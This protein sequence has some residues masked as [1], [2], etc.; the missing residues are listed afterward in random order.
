MMLAK[1]KEVKTIGIVAPSFFIEKNDKF[2]AGVN[3]LRNKGVDLKFGKT[4]FRRINNT[5]GTA[6]ERAN[7]INDMFADS[8]VDM[9]VASDGGCRAVEVLEYLDYDMIKKNPKPLCGFSDITHLLL[10]IYTKTDNPCIHGIDVING[11]GQS[12]SP[13]KDVN[14]HLFWGNIA[15]SSVS[16][17][18]NNALALKSGKGEGIIVGGWLNAIHNMVGTEY[19]PQKKNMILF[20]EAIE[21]EPNK[22]NMMLQSLRLS[23]VFEHLS[24]MIVGKLEACV[25]KEYYDCIPDISEIILDA[26][27]GYNFPILINAPFGHGDEKSSF[28]LGRN[29]KISTEDII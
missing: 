21:E 13:I 11:F 8:E 2:A 6:I 5:T 29:I 20:W 28:M 26:C 7:D 25:E 3:Y 1:N 18:L 16:M 4:V 19:F 17:N 12:D 22:I 23:G 14:M 27:K 24:G 10:A 9:I 15:N